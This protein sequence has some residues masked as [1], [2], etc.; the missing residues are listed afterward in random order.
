MA[1][2][3]LARGRRAAVA[4]VAPHSAVA[5]SD[6]QS[7][8]ILGKDGTCCS[9]K[10]SAQT[11]AAKEVRT[12]QGGVAYPA[13][14]SEPRRSTTTTPHPV[15]DVSH[16]LPSL[17]PSVYHVLLISVVSGGPNIQ[18][19]GVA[20]CLG[21]TGTRNAN[22]PRVMRASRRATGKLSRKP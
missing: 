20:S 19:I 3:A 9:T 13:A 10:K 21:G 8:M 18:L 14:T 11:S 22:T 6:L 2:H 17:E 4:L 1:C 7:V 5:R 15:R 12:Q 16:I